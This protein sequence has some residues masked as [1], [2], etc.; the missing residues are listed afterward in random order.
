M[1]RTCFA[2]GRGRLSA[3]RELEV[4]R[5]VLEEI[6]SVGYERFSYDSVAARAHCSKAT[7]YRLW[8]DK[9]DLVVNAIG[10]GTN[11]VGEPA[12]HGSLRG[13]LHA[14]AAEAVV[15][16]TARLLLAVARAAL[17]NPELAAA[18]RERLLGNP[19]EPI[20]EDAMLVRAMARGEVHPDNP[21][22]RQLPAALLGVMV[23]H[24]LITGQPL[25]EK[26]LRDYLDAV[27]IPALLT[28]PAKR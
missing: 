18:V 7:L 16:D 10:C 27:V 15:D 25:T 17:A 26:A 22:A 19:D 21:A 12:D 2:T 28:D 13:D 23:F 8:D 6:L 4:Y 24:E 20:H 11:V 3:E 14:W 5:A 1:G 9:V